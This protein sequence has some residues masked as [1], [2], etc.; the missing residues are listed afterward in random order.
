MKDFCRMA[1]FLDIGLI[2]LDQ[3]GAVQCWNPWMERHSRIK[4]Q[5]AVGLSLTELWPQL[6][7]TRIDLAIQKAIKQG[8]PSYLSSK[9]LSQPLPLFQASVTG[10]MPEQSIVQS[11]HVRQAEVEDGVSCCLISVTDVTS[12]DRR[13][14][15]L[16][17]RSIML[18]DLVESLKRKDFELSTLFQN[19]Q[20]GI[21][22]FDAEGVVQSA[23]PAA[24]S[25]FG[26][27]LNEG[28]NS[29]GQLNISGLIPDV[30][31]VKEPGYFRLRLPVRDEEWEM[32][33][34]ASDGSLFPVSV[35]ANCIQVNETTS[36]QPYRYFVFVRDI[37]EQKQAEKQLR[38]MAR[39]DG[40]TGLYNR[41]SFTEV[42]EEAIQFHGREAAS[43]SV[44]FI[45]LDRFKN[46]NDSHGHDIGDKLLRQVADRLKSC[47]RESDRIARW[48]GD[49]FVV[50]VQNQNKVR[51]TIT[52]AE[53]MLRSIERPFEV[54]G[55]SLFVQCSIGISQF[56]DDG[57]DSERLIFCA[58]QAM[59]QAKAE[60]KGVFRFFTQEM[61]QRTLKRL[62]LEADLRTALAENEFEL[63]YQP[64][65]NVL[66]GQ[67]IGVEALIR[68]HHPQQGLVQPDDFIPIAEDCGL[69][70]QLGEWVMAEAFETASKWGKRNGEP[71]IMSINLSP[72]QFVDASLVATMGRI[73]GSLGLAAENV[74]LEITEGHLMGEF[75]EAKAALNSLKALGVRIAIDDFG[76]GYSSLAYLRKLPVDIIKID[77]AF[78]SGT[79]NQT[80]DAKIVNAI[81]D[82]AHA[83]ELEVIAEGIEHLSQMDLLK[84]NGCDLAQGFYIGKPM[85][86]DSLHRW[87]I[88]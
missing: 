30:L 66:T 78:L 41:F 7:G 67:L 60:G 14:K 22:T 8:S 10:L 17:R 1:E 86:I 42:L 44:F 16:R 20:I 77:K 12:S 6:I 33:A 28:E 24:L 63:F 38:D 61:N 75:A 51:S 2:A 21:L 5:D 3:Q 73:L 81:I 36:D 43:L 39:F 68:W 72:K 35:S 32:L 69:I 48:A 83:L 55:R 70:G 4:Y 40:L 13:E 31:V 59:Y 53:K 65:V 56:P 45:D 23:N 57:V 82:L 29:G 71:L 25:L 64:Q 19:T 62:G 87:V 80:A 46:V 15:A 26:Y 52:V 18:S 27:P 58:D 54:E 37:R 9:L 50:L 79:E 34:K 76:T 74:V 85:N 11:I 47:C 84:A 88:Q 49:E